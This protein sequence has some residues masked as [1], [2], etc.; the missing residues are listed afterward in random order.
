MFCISYRIVIG[1]V[2]DLL[3]AVG[4]LISSSLLPP[5]HN[6]D[7]PNLCTE[8]THIVGKAANRIIEI[9]WTISQLSAGTTLTSL[10]DNINL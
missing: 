4:L 5:L 2:I 3:Y 6:H 9:A 10:K 7:N 8:L 1:R